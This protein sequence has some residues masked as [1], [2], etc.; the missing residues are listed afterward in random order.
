MTKKELFNLILE[1]QGWEAIS[2]KNTKSEIVK[3]YN[4]NNDFKPN[5]R[6]RDVGG[7]FGDI[8]MC[9][10][11]L[12]EGFDTLLEEIKDMKYYE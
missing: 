7:N 9:E 11:C 6:F 2:K 1:Y 12:S 4:C 3:C 8:H 5:I 10:E